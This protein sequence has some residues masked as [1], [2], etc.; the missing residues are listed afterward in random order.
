M[1]DENS[2]LL[3][4]SLGKEESY[5]WL[6]DKGS[7][8]SYVLPARENIEGRV[9]DLRAILK[10]REARGGESIEDYQARVA[11]AEDDY[12]REAHELSKVLLGPVADKIEGKRL[13]VVPDGKL[14]YFPISALPL[15]SVEGGVPLLLSNEVVY[16]PSA[17]TLSLLAKNRSRN[18]QAANDLLIF[19]DPVFSLDDARLAGRE[20]AASDP[21][22][23]NNS[24]D[25]F[26]FVESL[27]NLQR[28]P[29]S[30]SEASAIV[31]SIGGSATDSFSGFAASQRQTFSDRSG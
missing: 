10:A 29:G 11:K 14:L 15:P 26:R 12:W 23:E 2:V 19:S 6:V 16:E 21:E 28:L 3:E 17:Q 24:P 18:T 31:N 20:V 30:S 7:V 8:S 22:Q 27:K 13:I 5:L 9:E 4:Y 1:L 25:R